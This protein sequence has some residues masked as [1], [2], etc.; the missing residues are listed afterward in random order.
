MSKKTVDATEQPPQAVYKSIIAYDGTDFLGFQRQAGDSRTVQGVL[1]AGLRQIGWQGTSI[2][3]AG[4]TDTGV[5]ARGQVISFGLD[6]D[7]GSDQLTAALN[8]NLPQDVAVM[9]TEAVGDDFHPRFSAQSR[10]Y[11]YSVFVARWRD[12]LRERYA[13]RLKELPDFLSM[14]PAVTGLIGRKDFAAFGSAVSPEGNTV[15]EVFRADWSE[16][17]GGFVFE[18]E[19]DAFLYHMVRRITAAMVDVG[20]GR[21]PI[22]GFVEMIEDPEKGGHG[23][24]APAC[25]LCLEEVIYP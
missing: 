5:H 6:W 10:R 9:D 24:L 25:G 21:L 17:D 16:E 2:L 1:E 22:D 18:I 14:Q 19:A 15:R 13:W 3:A 11:R 20:K 4:R 12:P 23:S 8:A 7:H